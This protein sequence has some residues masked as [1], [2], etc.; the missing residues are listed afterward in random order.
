MAQFF[1]FDAEM[2]A[3]VF[4]LF[5]K[6]SCAWADFDEMF[7]LGKFRKT[8][9]CIAAPRA[10]ITAHRQRIVDDWRLRFFVKTREN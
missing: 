9:R 10:W 4:L 5:R 2:R 1:G 7:I 6:L 3:G 8:K